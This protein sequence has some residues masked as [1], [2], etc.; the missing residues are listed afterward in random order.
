MSRRGLPRIAPADLRDHATEERI[1]RVWDRIEHDLQARRPA[2]PRRASVAA[3]LAAAS[4]AAFAGGLWLGKA[5]WSEG[6]A[7]SAPTAAVAPV[8]DMPSLVDV[9]AAG[10]HGRTFQLPGGGTI[11]LTPGTTVEVEQA[12]GGALTLRLVQGEA[13]L[14]TASGTRTA[15]LS[16][17]AGEARLATAAGSVLRVKHNVDDIDVKVTDGQ[18]KLTSPAG[19]RELGRG[20]VA[21]EV[22]IRPPAPI[23]VAPSEL[24][25]P[26]VSPSPRASAALPP[27]EAAA[28]A[29]PA[30]DWRARYNAG[31]AAEALQSLRQQGGGVDG[32][33][34]S[35]R[36]AKELMDLTDLLRD[37]SADHSKGDDR[38]AAVRAL[39]RVV[40]SFPNDA[41]AQIAAFTL[42][43]MYAEMGDQALAAKYWEQV[44]SL[45]PEG[46]LA[47]DSFCK[48]IHA[49][50]VAGRKDEA[51]QMA[52]E[53]A[54]NYPDGRC[55]DVHQLLSGEE[56]A[57]EAEGEPAPPPQP[58][59][60]DA[61]PAP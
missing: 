56:A 17:V 50:V 2:S 28:A 45:S 12:L 40:E 16:I 58:A 42:G 38:A 60:P 53:Y 27:V 20:D 31:D 46:N 32:A 48:R 35:A 7:A 1:A 24:L 6:G 37:K 18:V 33:I 59:A 11:S 10:T 22:P 43:N 41:N 3:A 15:A 30:P 34:A 47:E 55:E 23:T 8:D 21:E 19:S 4:F 25:R 57:D 36:T 13:S 49:E 9:F 26:R 51:S 14:D 44:R 5:I 54:A 61:S 39:T 52:K 29:P